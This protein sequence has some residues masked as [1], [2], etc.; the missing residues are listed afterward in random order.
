MDWI[1]EWLP[2]NSHAWVQSGITHA[3]GHTFLASFMGATCETT[4]D[5]KTALSLIEK[6][7][8]QPFLYR[9]RNVKTEQTI[10]L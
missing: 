10:I 6:G 1:I 7:R 8:Q 2:P 4:F 5:L 9:V 3:D